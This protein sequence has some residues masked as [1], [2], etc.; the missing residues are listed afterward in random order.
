VSTPSPGFR[1]V[2][3]EYE[4]KGAYTAVYPIKVNQQREVV[5]AIVRHGGA[6]VGLE[7][8]SKPE[9]AAVLGVARRRRHRLQR[10]KD[11]GYV[12]AP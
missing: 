12:R 11:R 2:I 1:R 5:E 6:R 4:Y 9:L 7:A 3:A 8:G 10:Y